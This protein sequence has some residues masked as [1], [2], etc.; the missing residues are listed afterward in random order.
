VGTPGARPLLTAKLLVPSVRPGAVSRPRLHRRLDGGDGCRL[1]VVVAPAGW[2]K[3]T[4][5]SAWAADPARL[6]RVAWLSIDESDD[7]PVRFWTY[8]LSALEGVDPALTADA[9]SALRA[10]GLDP[11]SLAVEALL[12]AATAG[13]GG[14]VLVL[15]DYHLVRDP[16]IQESVEFLLS[17]LPP[18]L[19]LII[20][21]RADPPLPLARM[22]ARGVLTEIRSDELR[23]TADEGVALVSGMAGIPVTT[24]RVAAERA[25][26][27]PA[28]L[29][30]AALTLRSATD[31]AAAA[32][33]ISGG[34]RHLLDYFSSEVLP[35]IDASQRDLLVRASVLER[36][37]GPLCDAVLQR[38]DSSA[39]LEALARADLFITPLDVRWFRCHRLF[40]DVLRRELAGSAPDA[41]PELLGR[42]ADWFLAQG[43]VEQ[44]VEHR[45]AAGDTTGARALLRSHTR[46][47][48]DHGAMGAMLR[49][50]D[51]LPGAESD[52]HLCLDLAMAAG[53]SGQ[54]GRSIEWLTRA[55]P[56]I[57][58]D[59]EPVPGWRTMRAYADCTWAI[60]GTLDD[61]EAGLTYAR[62]AVE[63]ET[64]P[65][66]WGHVVAL[67]TLGGVLLAAGRISEAAEVLQRAWQ[68]RVRRDLPP[69]MVLQTAG[70]LALAVTELGE[71]DRASAVCAAVRGMASEAE[72]TWGE[73]AAAALAMVRLAEGRLT[74][75]TDPATAVTVL[76]RAVQLARHWGET[77]VLLGA[78]TSL[79]AAQ[80]ATG[81]RSGARRALDQAHHVSDTEPA[82]PVVVRELAELD[83]RIGR[84]ASR[85]ARGRRELVEDLTDRELAILRA[86]RGPLSA[87]EI[88]GEMHLSINTVKGY[89]KSLYRK[90]GVVTRVEAVRRGL[91]LGLI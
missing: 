68:V 58:A 86:L 11:I 24:A 84:A 19:H 4:L 38:S 90:L 20:A 60:Y 34:E 8:L 76:E 72:R 43:Q 69:L 80:W 5:L 7:E 23:C 64:D 10:P 22:R 82:R 30:L 52:P 74:A 53:L 16:V 67:N 35:G 62:R 1:T 50:G 89:S 79:A 77:T 75:A 63:L 83:A 3:T 66:R 56:Y 87:R 41:P 28:G 85:L 42:A 12:N 59:R 14:Y 78:L 37:S 25:E 6:H 29:Q 2:G 71:P 61:V 40:R 27:W 57:A 48:M 73:G 9:L 70:L 45:M 13:P 65:A 55:E 18:T 44:A 54:A 36:L 91:D 81:D 26:G 39:V 46:W 49:S 32:G 31:P 21:S 33:R 88:G 15:D 51:R 47:F 17:Y